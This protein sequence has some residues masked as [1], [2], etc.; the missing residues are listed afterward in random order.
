MTEKSILYKNFH[1]NKKIIIL[2]YT[3]LSHKTNIAFEDQNDG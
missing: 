2:I 1:K 3:I